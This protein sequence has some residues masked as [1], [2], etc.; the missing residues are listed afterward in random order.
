[1]RTGT[2]EE[3]L[4][5][6][7][8]L[9]EKE[10]Q[11]TRLRDELAAARRALPA[12]KVAEDYVFDAPDGEKRLADLFASRSQLI[13][14]HFMLGPQAQDPCKSC[15][16]WAE[17]YDGLRVHL[18]HRDTELVA[19]SRAPLAKIEEVRARMGWKFPW[20]SSNRSRFNFDYR[21]SFA[22]EDRGKPLYNFGTINAD[23]GELPGVSV[24]LRDGA[25][26]YHTYSAYSRG[27]DAL[28]CTYQ[29]LDLTPKGR[30]EEGLPST[31]AWLRLK[32]RYEV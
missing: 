16:F 10:K 23:N 26:V 28:N 1:M 14:Y 32:D 9:L 13:V 17:Q 25:D 24:F 18:P 22:D 7:L 11:L 8:A 27:L 31:N 3:W 2:R 4:G 6:R 12:V 29:L 30:D 5:E 20:V 19:V 21:V 15:S